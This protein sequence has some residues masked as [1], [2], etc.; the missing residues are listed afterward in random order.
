MP[1]RYTVAE[2]KVQ[3]FQL[4]LECLELGNALLGI[5]EFVGNGMAETG[6]VG[7]A[8]TRLFHQLSDLPKGQP[9]GLGSLDEPQSSHGFCSIEP[10]ARLGTGG[11]GLNNPCSS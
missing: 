5:S 6:K 1:M 10:I 3:A 11:R 7:G 4:T 9:E 8:T 2:P